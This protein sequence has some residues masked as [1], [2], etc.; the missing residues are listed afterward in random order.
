MISATGSSSTKASSSFR[1]STPFSWETST[2]RNLRPFWPSWIT[3]FSPFGRSAFGRSRRSKSI[4]SGS[5]T[6]SGLVWT[7]FL[8]PS[9][10]MAEPVGAFAERESWYTFSSLPSSETTLTRTGALALLASMTVTAVPF[11]PCAETIGRSPSYSRWYSVTSGLKPSR[12][13]PFTWIVT[14]VV[15]WASSVGA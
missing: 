14:S 10:G 7:R 12:S 4:S 1:L 3:R 8:T 13:L 6:N 5:I 9:S 11:L 15:A 2:K